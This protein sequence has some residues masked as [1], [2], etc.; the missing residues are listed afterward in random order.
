MKQAMENAGRSE[1]IGAGD[2]VYSVRMI[3]ISATPFFL[4]GFALIDLFRGRI[5][6]HQRYTQQR[7]E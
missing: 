7:L 3:F 4:F 1:G 5:T 6:F 2:K